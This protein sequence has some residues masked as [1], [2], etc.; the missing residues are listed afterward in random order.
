MQPIL[1]PVYTVLNFGTL[2]M[3]TMHGLPI[4]Y[5]HIGRAQINLVQDHRYQF[6]LRHSK[7]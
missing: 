4:I 1:M 6:Y 5:I 7:N 3:F 2:N